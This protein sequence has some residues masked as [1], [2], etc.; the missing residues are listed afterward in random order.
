MECPTDIQHNNALLQGER[1]YV[2]LDGLE[3]QLEK[4]RGDVLQLRPLPTIEQ[5]YAHVC[6]ESIRQAVMITGES[7]TPGVVLAIKGL[8]FGPL[9]ATPTAMV[10]RQ[11]TRVPSG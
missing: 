4:I 3:D 8:R 7:I 9:M 11:R 10:H 5:A 2:F 6:R 1:V